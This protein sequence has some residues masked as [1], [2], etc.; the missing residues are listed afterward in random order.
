MKTRNIFYL[1]LGF[2]ALSCAK[3]LAPE[4]SAPEQEINYISKTFTAGIS[5]MPEIDPN[6]QP[7]QVATK[8]SMV[9]GYQINWRANDGVT[10]IDNVAKTP[11]KYVTGEAGAVT[12]LNPATE[13]TG[14]AEGATE[15]YAAYPWRDGNNALQLQNGDELKNCYITPDQRPSRGTFYVSAHYAMAKA[16]AL[17]NLVFKNLNAFVKITLEPNLDKKV[18]AI[19]IFSNNDEELSG[20]FYMKWNNGDPKVLYKNDSANRPYVRAFDNS[21]L[22]EGSYYLS[23][24]PTTFEK[25]FTVVLQ[26]MDGTQMYKRTEKTLAVGEGQ[27]LPMKTLKK[28]EYSTD[29][30]NYFVLYNEGFDVN[31]GGVVINDYFTTFKFVSKHRNETINEAKNVYFVTPSA[32][33]AVI[34]GANHTEF[35][36]IGMNKNQRSKVKEN[37]NMGYVEGGSLYLFSNLELEQVSG[38]GFVRGTPQKFGKVVI[39]NCAFKNWDRTIL[40]MHNGTNYANSTLDAIIIEDSEFCFK[41]CTNEYSILIRQ[42][43]KLD[44]GLFKFVNNVVTSEATTKNFKFV[45]G[46]ASGS[47]TGVTLKDCVVTDNTFADVIISSFV[48]ACGITG[49]LQLSRNLF[50]FPLSKFTDI[51]SLYKDT[52]VSEI[53]VPQSGECGS[54]YYYYVDDDNKYTLA[55]KTSYT[56]AATNQA[57]IKLSER[58]VSGVWDPVKGK[59]GAYS[60]K[61]VS[62]TAPAYNEVGAQ[63]ADMAPVTAA[64]N[65]PAL[66][67]SEVNLGTF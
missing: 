5:S 20:Q 62:G 12:T 44:L 6:V 15:I 31:I 21:G 17:D 10:V 50:D 56:G 27:I 28:E 54:N 11:V 32:D 66:N 30:I 13:G 51:L 43:H 48:T 8:T 37:G 35:A 53:P 19:Y 3:E 61:V 14:V 55:L 41:G 58:A 40:D 33:D 46:Y 52:G 42:G 57:P 26:M 16:D 49:D 24:I 7:S 67:Y 63:R 22:K 2:L 39:S 65:S 34:S 36:V 18:K 47:G 60:F 38:C 9:N 59:F 23:I 1:A 64:L 4:T 45:G 29:D 25:G